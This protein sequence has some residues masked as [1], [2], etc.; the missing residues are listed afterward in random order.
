MPGGRLGSFRLGD[1]S[2]LLV[3]HLL[4]G[5]AFTVPVP[6]QEDIGIDFLCSLITGDDPRLLRAGAFFSVQAK[7]SAAPLPFEEPHALSWIRKQENPLLVCVADREAG[8]MDVYSTW[9]LLCGVLL[10]W[11]GVTEPNRITLCPGRVG[12]PWPGVKN[13]E[14]GS[15]EI[16]LGKPIVRIGH[17]QVFDE[18]YTKRIADLI[19]SWVTLDRQNIVNCEAGLNWIVGPL[20]YETGEPLGPDRGIAFYW[21]QKNLPQCCL[22]L[23][24]SATGVWRCLQALP[25]ENK[26][27][28]SWE[29][30]IAALRPTLE[31]AEKLDPTLATFLSELRADEST[32]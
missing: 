27:K 22:N 13:L 25:E 2:E 30:A 24:R 31:W 12:E 11:R 14:D 21:H 10:G 15:Q 28:G 19:G 29:E 32:S 3:Q 7:S 5:I 1:R 26:V 9:N 8:A 16:W 18:H 6:R 20:T 17:D 4:A 23:G